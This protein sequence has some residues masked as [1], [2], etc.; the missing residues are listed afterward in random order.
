MDLELRLEHC[1][2]AQAIARVEQGGGH[3]TRCVFLT[4]VRNSQGDLILIEMTVAATGAHGRHPIY[5]P[6]NPPIANAAFARDSIGPV[7]RRTEEIEVAQVSELPIPVAETAA[8]P[9]PAPIPDDRPDPTRNLVDSKS[10]D[11]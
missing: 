7:D 5:V 10:D 2:P 3:P 1:S 11:A 4:G 9:D 8:T 6:S